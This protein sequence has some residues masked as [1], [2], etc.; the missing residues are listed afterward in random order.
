MDTDKQKETEN[1]RH[2]STLMSMEE[3]SLVLTHVCLVCFY[4][5]A[6]MMAR[7]AVVSVLAIVLAEDVRTQGYMCARAGNHVLKY[8]GAFALP[9]PR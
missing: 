9:A 3:N 8:C 4:W 2:P 1:E 6:V 5:E 7:K